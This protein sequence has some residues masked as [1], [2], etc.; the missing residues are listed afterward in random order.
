MMH[1]LYYFP[2]DRKYALFTLIHRYKPTKIGSS[3]PRVGEI[4]RMPFI[5]ALICFFLISRS[6][7][8]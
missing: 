8:L 3:A 4:I 2:N 5:Y 1:Q 6:F 7:L